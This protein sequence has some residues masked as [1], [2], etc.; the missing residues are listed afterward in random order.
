MKQGSPLTHQ[1]YQHIQAEILAGRFAAGTLISETRIAEELGISRTPV[2]EAIRTLASEGWVEQQP[3]RGTI[4]RSFSRREIIELYELR[5]ALETF[6]AGKAAG[7]HFRLDLV[8]S[9]TVLQRDAESGQTT[10]VQRCEH[11]GRRLAEAISCRGHGISLARRSHGRQL[12]GHETRST[13]TD[14]FSRVPDAS[15]TP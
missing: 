14:D 15:S 2:G 3:R 1:A 10:C 7:S 4:V 13:D 6:A 12:E 5:E 9:G 8:A 11:A